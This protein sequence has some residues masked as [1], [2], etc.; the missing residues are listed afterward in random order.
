[1]KPEI[2]MPERLDASRAHGRTACGWDFQVRS[3][4]KSPTGLMLVAHALK[5]GFGAKFGAG[6]DLRWK[7]ARATTP[8]EAIAEGQQWYHPV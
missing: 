8:A 4:S 6:G 7:A 2:V 5:G 1:M 3:D